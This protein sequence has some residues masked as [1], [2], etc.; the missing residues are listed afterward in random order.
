MDWIQK[1]LSGALLPHREK[2]SD[3][4]IDAINNLVN[5]PLTPLTASDIYVRRCRLAGDAI[6][7]GFGRFRTEDLPKLLDFL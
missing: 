7:A 4:D 5:P 2:V 3:G 6:D 1:E